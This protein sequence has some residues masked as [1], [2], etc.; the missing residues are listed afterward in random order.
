MA[1][2]DGAKSTSKPTGYLF[3]QSLGYSCI[4]PSTLDYR[5]A[6]AVAAATRFATKKE[7][8]TEWRY[9]KSKTEYKNYKPAI[10]DGLTNLDLSDAAIDNLCYQRLNDNQTVLT[11]AF[12][13]FESWPAD[14]QL[15]LLSMAWAM[16]PGFSRSWPQF[17]AA[18][19]ELDFY[20]A[21]DY[22][23]MN[24]ATNPGLV[25]RNRANKILFTNAAI[26]RA[27]PDRYTASTLYYPRV[28]VS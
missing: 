1:G 19:R 13:A 10:W 23:Q 17:S 15:A 3:A 27:V 16:G 20:C 22:C 24:D 4:K 2:N 26:V 9:I 14:A 11:R 28:L 6:T 5:A 7:I 25:P 12:P 18:C 8:E 21:A